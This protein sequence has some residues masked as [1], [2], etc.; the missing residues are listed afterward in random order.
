MKRR[1]ESEVRWGE[2]RNIWT[3]NR[4]VSR[5]TQ[6]DKGWETRGNTDRYQEDRKG[7]GAGWGRGEE[8]QARERLMA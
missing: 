5:S 6:R 8:S 7:K 4:E 3:E 2:S 1:K